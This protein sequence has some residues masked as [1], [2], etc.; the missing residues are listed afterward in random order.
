M[1]VL[2]EQEAPTPETVAFWRAAGM[3][4]DLLAQRATERPFNFADCVHPLPLGFTRLQDLPV[5]P[6]W[7]AQLGCGHRRRPCARTRDF[8]VAGR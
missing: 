7:R 5:R 8:L 3:P 6:F 4:P 2:D 1:L